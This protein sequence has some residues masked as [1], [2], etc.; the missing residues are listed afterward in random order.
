VVFR[1]SF[2]HVLKFTSNFKTFL[3]NKSFLAY[4]FV[5]FFYCFR[6]VAVWFYPKKQIRENINQQKTKAIEGDKTSETR[7]FCKNSFLKIFIVLRHFCLNFFPQKKKI[8][9]KAKT[10]LDIGIFLYCKALFLKVLFSEFFKL[11]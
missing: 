1:F 5:N 11:Q 2:F 9:V 3:R 8:E 10:R 6:L 4:F 7:N